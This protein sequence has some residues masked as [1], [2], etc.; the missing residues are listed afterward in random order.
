MR[1]NWLAYTYN[2]NV[3]YGKY[4]SRM[5]AALR[6]QGVTVR[7][8]LVASATH[9]AW[10][11]EERGMSWEYPTVTCGPPY[12]LL[13]LPKGAGPHWL[14]T[15]TE[16]GKL[17]KG[18]AETINKCKLD[19]IIVPCEHNAKVF[20]EG[21]VDAPVTVI[22]GGTDPDEFPL[23]HGRDASPHARPYTF[24]TLADRG[25]RKGWMEV[26]QAF[27]AAFGEKTTAVQNVRLII[28]CRPEGN[29][30]IDTILRLG[31]DLDR[32]IT[33]LV[34][35]A[36]NLGDLYRQVDCLALPSR[37][38]GWGMPH[39]EAAMMGLPVITQAHSGLDDG[40]TREWALVLENGQMRQIGDEGNIAGDWM[41]ADVDELAH[42]MRAVYDEPWAYHKRASHAREWLINNQTWGHAANAL[43]RLMV[44]E[45]VLQEEVYA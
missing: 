11:L 39:R 38:E 41:I 21:G 28:K 17:P 15:M 40:Y 4:S 12:H 2:E 16:G 5:V 32:R 42:M 7:P 20:R 1:L 25:Y 44:D 19:R 9:P 24:L 13:R 33:Y 30:L 3:G 36:A 10:L 26:Y 37:T 8:E 18:W 23:W 22:P 34:D 27:F 35:D 6:A 29:E 45:G 43:I 14:L 31:H